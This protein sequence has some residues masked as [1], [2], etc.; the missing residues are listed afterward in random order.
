MVAVVAVAVMG[1]LSKF[2]M[3]EFDKEK[4]GIAVLAFQPGGHI[5]NLNEV[6]R[7]LKMTN[8]FSF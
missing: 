2:K 8:W 6:L 5:N 3:R 4:E 1:A 7:S